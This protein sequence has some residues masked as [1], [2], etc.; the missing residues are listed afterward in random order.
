MKFWYRRTTDIARTAS[1]AF[2]Y[3]IEQQLKFDICKPHK[4]FGTV[5]TSGWEDV[6]VSATFVL[7]ITVHLYRLSVIFFFPI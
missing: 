2:I 3:K 1:E 5:P 4:T 7:V 6:T